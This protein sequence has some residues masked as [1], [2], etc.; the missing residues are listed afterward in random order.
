MTPGG[1]KN[2]KIERQGHQKW[3]QGHQKWAKGH[4]KWA[5]REPKG[6]KSEPKGA[7]REPKGAKREPKVSPIQHKIN[8]K[9]KVAKRS[10]KGSQNGNRIEWNLGG[11]LVHFRWKVDEKIDVKIYTEK[12]MNIDEISMRK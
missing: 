10:R 2:E 8:I 12:V 11:F 3:A 5:K 1:T 6:A 7:K 9:D 4:Q